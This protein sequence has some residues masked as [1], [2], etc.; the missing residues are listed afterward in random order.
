M[1]IEKFARHRNENFM[2]KVLPLPAVQFARHI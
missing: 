2:Q 1:Q